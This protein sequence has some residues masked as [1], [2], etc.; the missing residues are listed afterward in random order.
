[1]KQLRGNMLAL[2]KAQLI[3]YYIEMGAPLP[4]TFNDH[5]SFL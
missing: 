3:Q 5:V 1:M 4:M 2:C